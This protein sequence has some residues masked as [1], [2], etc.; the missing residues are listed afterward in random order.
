MLELQ[1]AFARTVGDSL[2]A[3]MISIAGA[4][5]HDPRDP[6]RLG[7]LRQELAGRL[8][9]GHLP[10]PVHLHALAQ[11]AHP[12]Q[13]HAA[14]VVYQVRGDVLERAEDNQP[15][16]LRRPVDPLPN[17]EMA[18]VPP[19]SSGLWGV[20]RS[21]SYFAPV[22]PALRRTCSPWYRMPLPLYGSG[23]RT[24]RSSAAT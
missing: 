11:V 9:L 7:L 24:C 1:S 6:G 19:V 22:L 5:E 21:H 15:G 4:V 3:T 23:G 17:P 20:D 18:A 13:C 8:A 16:P 12:E 14:I 10:A 2:H